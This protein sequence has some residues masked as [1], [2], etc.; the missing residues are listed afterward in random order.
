MVYFC[1]ALFNFTRFKQIF[2]KVYKQVF[3]NEKIFDELDL[4][5]AKLR[6]GERFYV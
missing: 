2:R 3:M 6:K 4:K 5:E 1:S